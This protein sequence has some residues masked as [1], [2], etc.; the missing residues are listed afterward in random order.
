[1]LKDFWLYISYSTEA[2]FICLWLY[3]VF[4]RIMP[5]HRNVRKK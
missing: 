2:I 1:V 5:P 4:M 3:L